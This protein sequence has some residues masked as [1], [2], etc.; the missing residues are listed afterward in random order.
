MRKRIGLIAVLGLCL[1]LMP[2]PVQAAQTAGTEALGQSVDPLNGRTEPDAKD[3]A[4]VRAVTAVNIRK[5]PGTDAEKSGLADPGSMWE[6]LEEAEGWSKI[7]YQEGIGYIKSEYVEKVS[8]AEAALAEESAGNPAG[9]E[10]VQGADT[11]LPVSP[12]TGI[13]HIPEQG[14]GHVVAID[15]GH[16]AA[17]NNEKEPIGPGASQ[18]KAK[19][20]GG[21]KGV[22]SGVPEYQLTLTV[23]LQ[24]RDELLKRGYTV[25]MIRETNDINLSNKERAELAGSL[26]AEAFLR[27]HADGANSSSAHGSSALCPTANSPYCA[28]IYGDSRRLSESVLSHMTA[29]T[30][31]RNRGVTETDAMSGINWCSVPVSIVEMGF[32]TNPEEDAR[33][34]DAAYQKKLVQGM[35][36]G[37]DAYFG[38]SRE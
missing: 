20:A 35:A 36:D 24:L 33:M 18:E 21:T 34:Q 30:G 15:P 38:M 12:G 26:G 25:V 6:L 10:S 14:N 28:G 27:L 29:L 16:Q 8:A 22:S 4:Y 17:G 31:A 3:A 1:C 7:V 2:T 5:G 9:G 13:V 32:M 23:A 19:V 37:L 11:D